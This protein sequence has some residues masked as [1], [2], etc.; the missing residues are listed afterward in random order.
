[1]ALSPKSQ[2]TMCHAAFA[3]TIALPECHFWDKTGTQTNTISTPESQV[4]RH[5][6]EEGVL[7]ERN[8]RLPRRVRGEPLDAESARLQ[9][10]GLVQQLQQGNQHPAHPAADDHRVPNM[11]G[12]EEVR[13][14]HIRPAREQAPAEQAQQR[15]DREREE[16]EEEADF[17]RARVEARV[18]HGVLL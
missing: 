4:Q 5:R 8:L 6:S 15:G 10:D 1:M 11:V 17:L 16:G 9:A 3:S 2:T 12:K 14:R 13:L 7:E 18:L